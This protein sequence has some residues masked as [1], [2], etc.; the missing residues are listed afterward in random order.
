[1]AGSAS[2]SVP[3]SVPSVLAG[4]VSVSACVRVNVEPVVLPNVNVNVEVAP[5][6]TLAEAKALLNVGKGCTVRV[7]VEPTA[8][9]PMPVCKAPAAM[10]L[11]YEVSATL[12]VT[13]TATLQP[14]AG[15]AP[16]V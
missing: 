1:V 9:L 6:R 14:P 8:L 2:T 12:D 11:L 16:P 5:A 4:K 7:A 10:V 3:I 15:M 13:S